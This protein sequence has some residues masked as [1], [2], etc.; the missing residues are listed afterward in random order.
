MAGQIEDRDLRFA[1]RKMAKSPGFTSI[2][3]L[4]LA[5]GIG[6]NTAIFSLVNTLLLSGLPLRAPEELVE[7]YTSE[8]SNG[9]EPG[10]PYSISSYPDMVDLRERTDVFSGVAG[11]EAFFSRLETATTTEPIWGET[12]SWNLFSMLGMEPAVGRFFVHEE[13]Q[14]PGTHPVAVLGHDFWQRRY[15]GERCAA[16]RFYQ[17]L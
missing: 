12:V 10:Y 13:G 2:A 9:D 15:G 16:R 3:I 1:L 11:Y 5:L 6:A 14:T 7:V 4:S 8:P 17:G